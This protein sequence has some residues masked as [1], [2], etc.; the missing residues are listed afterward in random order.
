[1]LIDVPQGCFRVVFTVNAVAE[2]SVATCY[3]NSQVPSQQTTMLC[4][5]LG[6]IGPV[7]S[8]QPLYKSTDRLQIVSG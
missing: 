4:H 7:T 3:S 1:M 6:A 8:L 5:C 2:E